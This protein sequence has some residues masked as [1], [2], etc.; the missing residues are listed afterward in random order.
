MNLNELVEYIKKSE[1]HKYLYHFTDARNID[2]I[3]QHGLLSKQ[4]LESRKVVPKAFGGNDLSHDLDREQGLYD[5]VNLCFTRNHPMAY[6]AQKDGRLENIRYLGICPSIIL[7]PETKLTLNIANIP[8]EPCLDFAE[9]L[10]DLDL[11]VIYT[12]T[13]WTDPKVH[14]R[15][16]AAERCEILVPKFVPKKFIKV[17][18]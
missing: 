4:E 11:D 12:R 15:L 3:K 18:Y 1:Q 8:E 9:H 17:L 2:S 7:E 5:Y 13:K 16:I 14:A 6:I 10:M